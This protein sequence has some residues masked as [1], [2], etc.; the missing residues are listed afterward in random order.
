M[1]HDYQSGKTNLSLALVSVMSL[2]LSG[3]QQIL[4][5]RDCTISPNAM[6][7][8]WCC[9]AA[10]DGEIATNVIQNARKIC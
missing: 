7:L 6:S 3:P 1:C 5:P 9:G 2:V 8:T 10:S 4:Y